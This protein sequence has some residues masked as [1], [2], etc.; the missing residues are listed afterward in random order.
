MIRNTLLLAGLL[1][2][3]LSGCSL[4]APTGPVPLP[5]SRQILR[6]GMVVTDS[7]LRNLDPAQTMETATSVNF[8]GNY[9][10][11][12]S[13]T[14]SGFI[15]SLLFPPLL[16]VDNHLKPEPWATGMPVF[17]P[18]ADTYTFKIRPGLKWSDGT[19]IDAGT[20]A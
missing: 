9:H 19:P 15:A 16:T 8:C 18:R 14:S 2:V 11:L 12:D 20:Y 10:L 3:L 17:D 4:G 13:C 6:I 1:G 7:D 5:A